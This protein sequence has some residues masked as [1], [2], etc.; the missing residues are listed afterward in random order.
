[1]LHTINLSDAAVEI[2]QLATTRRLTR[3][4]QALPCIDAFEAARL[5]F[6]Q[7]ILDNANRAESIP[8]LMENG[9][10]TILRQL[11]LDDIPAIQE[12]AAL[13]L[14]RLADV[15]E[16]VADEIVNA[17]ILPEIVP[18][19][20]SS[21]AYYRRFACLT[22]RGIS[23]HSPS[24]AEECLP[25]LN[26]LVQCLDHTDIRVLDASASAVGS[27]AGHSE[28]LAQAVVDAGAISSLIS[29]LGHTELFVL[30]TV[31]ES[32]GQI[33]KHNL[34]LAVA[35]IEAKGIKVIVPLHRSPDPKLKQQVA[36][37]LT[38]I[39]KHSTDTAQLIVDENAFPHALH[40]FKDKD[41]GVRTYSAALVREIVKHTQELS[42]YV[43]NMGG[44]AALVA[45]LKPESQNEPLNGVLTV[46]FI[47]SFSQTLTHA[48]IDE[49]ADAVVL[50]VFVSSNDDAVQ[51]AAA[52]AMG[53][54]GKHSPQEA[55]RLASLNALSLLLDAYNRPGAPDDLKLKCKRALKFIITKCTLLSA[56]EP[57]IAPSPPSVQYYTLVQIEKLLRNN[58]N[59]RPLSRKN[60]PD[61]RPG[62]VMSGA[63]KAIQVLGAGRAPLDLRTQGVIKA[64]NSL[65]KPGLVQY[66]DPTYP[67]ALL[68]L[69]EQY[70][71]PK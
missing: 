16:T 6:V 50:N 47:A 71:E 7:T 57:L 11:L 25:L 45:F 26:P 36:R 60:N 19:L 22:I 15:N 29:G 53:Q 65:F 52:W 12:T 24:H 56:L 23:R 49:G 18:G 31:V 10:L 28:T 64:I 27:L 38:H 4:R 39:A 51:T 33:A 44:A 55:S 63:F 9:V 32:L 68:E 35:V 48:L 1:M 41:I 14:A 66:Y 13:A 2:E 46:G 58:A 69:T 3:A 30:R 21:D 59:A 40:C 43:I 8:T 62:F 37:T 34:Q 42:Q 70:E 67:D 5:E 17:G 20:Q 54:L 61:A